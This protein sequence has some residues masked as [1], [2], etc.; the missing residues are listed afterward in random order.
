MSEIQFMI[1]IGLKA[2]IADGT[3][4]VGPFNIQVSYPPVV[5]LGMGPESLPIGLSTVFQVKWTDSSNQ[6]AD[7]LRS[8]SHHR[9]LTIHKA[10]GAINEL[11]QAYKLVRMGLWWSNLKGHNDRFFQT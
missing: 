2:P 11:L 3:Y 6:D 1:G 5:D 4:E 9:H 10:L 7:H 8:P